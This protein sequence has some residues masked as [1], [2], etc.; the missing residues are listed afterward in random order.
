MSQMSSFIELARK[1]A[2]Q[3]TP[4]KTATMMRLALFLITSVYVDS[5]DFRTANLPRF[6]IFDRA[7][8]I[9]K[10]TEMQSQRAIN[11]YHFC[12]HSSNSDEEYR[13]DL[14]YLNEEF[15][16]LS[17]GQNMI[18]FQDFL[19][20]EAIQAILT[21]ND[22]DNYIVDIEDIWKSQAKSLTNSIDLPLFISINRQIDDLFEYV[23]EDEEENENS[24]AQDSVQRLSDIIEGRNNYEEDAE[25][26]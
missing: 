9:R 15:L 8:R 17:R 12:L 5:F 16:R 10:A 4:A 1:F 23:D 7:V 2:A 19:G 11:P 25:S 18:S 20:S 13:E 22:S 6:S 21:D 24:E 3:C 14:T 26:E